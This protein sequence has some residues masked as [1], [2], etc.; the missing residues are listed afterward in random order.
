[1][2]FFKHKEIELYLEKLKKIISLV[3][4]RVLLEKLLDKFSTNASIY[5]SHQFF[6]YLNLI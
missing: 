5:S 1:M 3:F 2:T 6:S 4:D